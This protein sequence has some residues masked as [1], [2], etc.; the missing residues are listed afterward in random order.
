MT[1]S[2]CFHSR[3]EVWEDSKKTEQKQ[4][5]NLAVQTWFPVDSYPSFWAQSDVIRALTSSGNPTPRVLLPTA[6]MSSFLGRLYSVTADFLSRYPMFLASSTSGRLLQSSGL[7]L[8]TSWISFSRT[9]IGDLIGETYS[10]FTGFPENFGY[11]PTQSCDLHSEYWEVCAM[12]MLS[13]SVASSRNSWTDMGHGCIE[14][15][16]RQNQ[17]NTSL[18]SNFPT[19]RLLT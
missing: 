14:C 7:T 6:H 3:R 11:K 15:L 5:G 13:S 19:E 1:Q 10:S 18:G 16:S 4:D 2:K 17:E 9:P 8:I 12:K